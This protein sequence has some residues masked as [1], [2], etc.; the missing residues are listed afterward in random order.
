MKYITISLI[1]IVA[2]ALLFLTACSSKTPDNLGMSDGLFAP[3]P[4]SP[5]C[6]S[7]QASDEEHK[8]NPI[9]AHG[10]EDKVMVDLRNSIESLFGGKVVEEEGPYLRAE[11]T[12]NVMRFI[13]DLECDYDEKNGLI[14]IR[15]A[16]RIGYSDLNANR[17]RVEELRSVFAKT[18][19]ATR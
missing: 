10:S 8:I 2:F 4:D 19:Q 15:S 7:T 5:N 17:K 16:S 14:Q 13:D 11:F 6:V 12:S 1:L 9:V 3:C 18:Q